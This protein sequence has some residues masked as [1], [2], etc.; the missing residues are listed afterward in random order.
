[1]SAHAKATPVGGR[2]LDAPMKG[3]LALF[4]VSALVV[5]YRFA[6]GM[7]AVSNMTDGYTWG[8][9]EPVN[10]VVFTGVGA[11]AYG[12]ALLCYLLNKG[13]YHGLVRLS[14][15]VGAISYTLGA[16]S[17]LVALGR[18]WNSYWLP[19]LPYWNLSSNLLEVAICV[20]SYVMVLWLE[21]LPAV[22][23]GAAGSANPRWRTLGEAWG[24]RL[25]RVMPYLVALAIVLPTMHQSSLGG[26]MLIAGPKIHPLW[27]NAL[28]PT[29]FLVSCLSMGY[30]AIVAL[31]NVL[32]IT[33]RARADLGLLAGITRV[34]G[35]LLVLYLVLRVG[36]VVVHGKLRYLGANFATLLFFLELALFAAP[37]AMS[38]SPVVAASRGKLYMAAL[39][40]LAAGALYRID[41]YL[42]MYRPAGWIDG[43]AIPSGWNYFPS[44]GET[45]VTMGAISFGLAVFIGLSRFFPV[46]VRE[47]AA[48]PAS[49]RLPNAQPA[50]NP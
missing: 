5:V 39:L 2:L 35:V 10:V 14:V 18:P 37:A 50:G 42:T 31:L 33:W 46:V 32:R 13:Q 44:L 12:V 22:L 8:I 15:L 27:H 40:S 20:L 26:L 38:F 11:G 36:E 1:V 17:I 48:P 47:D 7:G 24:P 28:L 41:V 21:V 4:A 29:L 23:E 16:T 34:N 43:V 3:L 6:A 30:G 49:S 25:H 19:Y 9:W 45:V